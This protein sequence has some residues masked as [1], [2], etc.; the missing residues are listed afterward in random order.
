MV[1]FAFRSV[2]I[3]LVAVKD[4]GALAWKWEGKKALDKYQEWEVDF[5]VATRNCT[6]VK[7]I[8][9]WY[10]EPCD[11]E[12]LV[13]CERRFIGKTHLVQATSLGIIAFAFS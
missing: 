3:S 4:N 1:M 9:R 13:M 8:K 5:P 6:Y 7:G 11:R 12:N 10:N 2:W